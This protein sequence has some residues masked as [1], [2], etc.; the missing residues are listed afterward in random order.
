MNKIL[1]AFLVAPVLG[2]GLFAQNSNKS[3]SNEEIDMLFISFE[4]EARAAISKEIKEAQAEKK[5]LE[6]ERAMPTSK[7]RN[8][9]GQRQ[10]LSYDAGLVVGDMKNQ[11]N[12]AMPPPP[13]GASDFNSRANGLVIN[14]ILCNLGK[15]EAV[16]QDGIL[17]KGSVL[18]SGEKIIKITKNEV[19]TS[20]RKLSF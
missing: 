13:M 20:F 2:T 5:R 6:A 7:K 11:P 4:Q 17:K 19:V 8:R 3:L 14:G 18:P 15:C 9:K 1:T 16:T 10:V 12:G